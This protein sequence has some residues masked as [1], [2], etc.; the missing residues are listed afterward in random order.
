M[1]SNAQQRSKA[2]EGTGVRSNRHSPFDD[3][4]DAGLLLADEDHEAAEQKGQSFA[5]KIFHILVYTTYML[6]R[7]RPKYRLQ[8]ESLVELNNHCYISESPS[9]QN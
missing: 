3:E 5:A 2:G 6:I 7:Q 8:L 9:V 1:T 4:L